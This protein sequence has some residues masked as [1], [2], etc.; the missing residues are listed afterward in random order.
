MFIVVKRYDTLDFVSE[1][2]LVGK[3]NTREEAKEA[4]KTSVNGFMEPYAYKVDFLLDTYSDDEMNCS[5]ILEDTDRD[6]LTAHWG[7]LEV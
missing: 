2:D 3:Y 4:M 6:E 5:V 1:M 7:I